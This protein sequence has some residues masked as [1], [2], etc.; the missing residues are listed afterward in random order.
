MTT[1]HSVMHCT[2]HVAPSRG[3]GQLASVAEFALQITSSVGTGFVASDVSESKV[4]RD[5]VSAT[6]WRFVLKCLDRT[7]KLWS[8]P[9]VRARRPRVRNTAA[10][11]NA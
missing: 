9:D 10:G 3:P 2:E 6:R 5:V 11:R 4:L 7:V 8:E 1:P